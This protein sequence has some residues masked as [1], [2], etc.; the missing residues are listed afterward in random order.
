LP[1]TQKQLREQVLVALLSTQDEDIARQYDMRDLWSA[2][3]SYEKVRR[4]VT[5]YRERNAKKG[6]L[7]APGIQPWMTA[8]LIA[9]LALAILSAFLQITRRR[10]RAGAG[11]ETVPASVNVEDAEMLSRFASLTKREREVLNLICGGLSSKVIAGDLGIS[12]KTVEYHRA[13]LLLKTK[14]GTTPQMVQYATRLGFDD[15]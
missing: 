6:N 2:P 12:T 9:L 3:L 15:L 5:A 13:N 10:R 4:L 1:A 7:L 11:G 14:A 8:L